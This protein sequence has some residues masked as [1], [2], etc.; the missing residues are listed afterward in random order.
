MVVWVCGR[1]CA[2]AHGCDGVAGVCVCGG[3][4]E[5]V[6]GR[7]SCCGL[8]KQRLNRLFFCPVASEVSRKC[9]II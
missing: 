4:G 7:G 3:G 2:W 6:V 1:G 9:K 5:G 8:H